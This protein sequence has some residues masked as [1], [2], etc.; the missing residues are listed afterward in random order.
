[1]VRSPAG[2]ACE[3]PPLARGP[4]G[5]VRRSSADRRITPARAGT[6]SAATFPAAWP[7]DHPRSRGDRLSPRRAGR[8]RGGSPPLA[9]GPASRPTRRAERV[10]IT[11]ARA[12]TGRG[13]RP[14]WPGTSDHPRSR[15]DRASQISSAPR[16]VGSPPLARGPVTALYVRPALTRITPARAGT[17]GPDPRCSRHGADHPRSRGDRCTRAPGRRSNGGSPPLAR[18]PGRVQAIRPARSRITPARAGTGA[19]SS[20]RPGPA[21][22]HPRSRGDRPCP[23]PRH[24]SSSGSP[25]LARG[26]VEL[27]DD[28]ALQLRI[29][30]ARAGTGG[31]TT[32]SMTRTPDHPRSRGDRRSSSE[33]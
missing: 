30:P 1:M 29:T 24:A 19:R 16:A 27:S 31:T 10:R 32:R 23:I 18:G 28:D 21:T 4:A 17:G 7:S 12:G 11:P 20:A 13:S 25:P 2:R 14:T 15:G 22:D 8:L 5:R 3:V 6:G 26:P 33:R 9:R